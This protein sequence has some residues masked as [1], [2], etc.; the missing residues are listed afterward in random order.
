MQIRLSEE[1]H[2]G[3]RDSP[4]QDTLHLATPHALACALLIRPPT[5]CI[6]VVLFSDMDNNQQ[7]GA[8]PT[9]L[10]LFTPPLAR[11]ILQGK[12]VTNGS[13]MVEM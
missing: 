4:P 9:T 6:G 1:V 7:K 11:D 2:P 5:L 12:M 10:A 3:K 13:D 8:P